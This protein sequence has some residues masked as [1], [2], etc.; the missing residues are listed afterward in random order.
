MSIHGSISTIT[1]NTMKK[2]KQNSDKIVCLT[3][4]DYT[5]AKIIDNAGIDLILVGDSLGMVVN[6]YDSTLPVTLEEIIYHTKSVG[7]GIKR[8][9]LVA[10][11]PFGSYQ[12]SEDIAVANCLRVIKETN[13][14][15][16]KLEG[17]LE[18]CNIIKRLT[19]C[20]VNVMG[21]IGLK[22]QHVNTM[23][24]YK[25]QGKNGADEL[26]K[27][28]KAI[29]NAGAFALVL[30]GVTVESAKAV[31][32]AINIPTIGIGS[33]KYCDG[34]I[35]VFHDAFGIFTDFEPKFVKKYADV[36]NIITK[37]TKDYID[38]VKKGLFP[39]DNQSF[40]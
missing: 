2:M 22:P 18:I 10:D 20:G 7:K 24:G 33:G 26:I 12:Q 28:A 15:A 36:A 21:H 38:D 39:N 40:F 3:A 31:T 30:E 6:G 29:E 25:I 23:G 16:V 27:E 8:G 34:Q 9:F 32:E 19:N 11:M 13:A 17:G 5:S 14:K 35:L 1:V 4:Y 37:G